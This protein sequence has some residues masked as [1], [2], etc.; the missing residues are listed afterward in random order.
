MLL[1]AADEDGMDAKFDELLEQMKVSG[2]PKTR[3]L[4]NVIRK[5]LYAR[6]AASAASA[7]PA[8][9]VGWCEASDPTSGNS[10]YWNESDPAGT[11]TWE[12]PI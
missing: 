1:R 2:I 4:D 12:S 10:Y 11:T 3:D 7:A 6:P 5:R 8:L 9:P